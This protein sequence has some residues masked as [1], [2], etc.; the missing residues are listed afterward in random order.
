M[1]GETRKMLKELTEAHAVPGFEGEVRDLIRR[2]MAPITQIETD[3]IG[4][5]I[6]KKVGDPNGP[7]VM[8]P[9]HMDEIGFMVKLIT[10][11]GFLRFSPLGGWFDQVLLSQ[12]VVVKGSKGDVLGIVGSK[13]PH[14]LSPE[15]RGKIVAKA[16]M[17]VDV[18]A[19]SDKEAE[20]KFGIRVG[21]PIVPDAPFTEMKN[22][23]LLLAKA[24]DDRV[25]CGL[26]IS[27]IRRLR[28]A[29]H[30]NIVCGVGTVQEE[31]GTRGARTTG[32]IVKPDVCLV[33]ES[34]IGADTPGMKPEQAVGK[35]GGGPILY[36]LDAGMIG[37]VKL[38]DLVIETARKSRIPYQLS[39]LEG[40]ATDGRE[41][42]LYDRGVPTLFLGVPVRYIHSHVGLLHTDDYDHAVNLLVAVIKRLDA[43]T[44]KKLKE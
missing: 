35:L 16:D 27:A 18:G 9:G 19:S 20:K 26:F 29:G 43:K 31:V 36:L 2:Y 3:N 5:I 6:C 24:W 17:F 15:E 34:G 12:R 40:G 38:R 8:I 4:G 21:D 14:L 7:V 10:K 44:V 37:H 1:D 42:H 32:N 25:G 23:K 11:E 22:P 41:I 13:P 28:R 39:V 33:A 30:P